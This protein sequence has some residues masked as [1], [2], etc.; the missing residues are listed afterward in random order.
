DA[1]VFKF[2]NA[3]C[4]SYN[5]SWIVIHQCRL[6]AIS[7]TKITFNFNGTILY[8]SSNIILEVQAFKKANGYKP[9]LFK[10]SLDGCRFIKK[11]YNPAAILVYNLFKEFT[12]INHTCPY[13]GE[14][15]IDG[16]Y[17]RPE[18]LTLPLPS[19]D[20]L[21]AVTWMFSKHKLFITNLYFTFTED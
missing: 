7:R 20:Y 12:N 8:P 16:F 21:L 11:S 6:R 5:E 9:W 19:G 4:E 18:L 10:F 14:Q 3:V 2:T 17:L 15:I 1:V 13:V